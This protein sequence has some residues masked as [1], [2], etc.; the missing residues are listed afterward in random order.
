MHFVLDAV[1][2]NEM[3]QHV[4]DRHLLSPMVC[5]IRD[6]VVNGLLSNNVHNST[7]NGKCF[8]L[9]DWSVLNWTFVWLPVDRW[10]LH[11]RMVQICHHIEILGIRHTF[12]RPT[13]MVLLQPVYRCHRVVIAQIEPILLRYNFV[14]LRM[15]HDRH[16]FISIQRKRIKMWIIKRNSFSDGG[17]LGLTF[18]YLSS[19][20]VSIPA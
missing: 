3:V 9:V 4:A 15:L 6:P 20:S 7:A 12:D 19:G 16:P 8:F 10:R 13:H 11:R 17:G 18:G 1:N 2:T 14:D 5:D